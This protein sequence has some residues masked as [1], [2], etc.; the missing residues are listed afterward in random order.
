MI[1]SAA[2][3]AAVLLFCSSPTWADVVRLVDGRVLEGSVT[4]DGEYLVIRHRFGEARVHKS[5]VLKI[6]DTR[7]A[8]DQLERL[9][10]ELANGTADERY[11]YATFAREN[12]FPAEAKHAFLSVLRVDLDH[13]GARAALGYVRHEGRWVTAA[14]KNR[15]MGLVEHKGDWVKPEEKARLQEVARKEAEERREAKDEA[16]RKK[17]E[18]RLAR[19]AA[20]R[21]A[22]RDRIAA[23]DAALDRERARRR[24]ADDYANE[25]GYGLTSTRGYLYNGVIY[26]S[27]GFQTGGHCEPIRGPRGIAGWRCT[28][29][30]YGYGRQYRRSYGTRLSGSYDGGKW[31]VRW[32]V[33][34]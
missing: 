4:P 27:G 34:F 22:R 19:K 28:T 3:L 2:L 7:D 5:D 13:P 26:P 10:A 32:R 12:G 11:R 21:E 1:R 24:I 20:E 8:W 30:S 31:G 16:K 15:L 14:D 17:A 6:E 33:G 18:A 29:P 25:S 9:R 23:Y